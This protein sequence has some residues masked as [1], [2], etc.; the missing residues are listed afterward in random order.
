MGFEG[1]SECPKSRRAHEPALSHGV[2]RPGGSCF[3]APE[4]RNI[5]CMSDER[6]ASV[7]SAN[8]PFP[9]LIDLA[10]KGLG[11]A[12]DAEHELFHLKIRKTESGVVKLGHSIRYTIIC[13]LGLAGTQAAGRQSPIDVK[14][15]LGSLLRK[16]GSINDTGDL[17]LLFWLCSTA[18]PDEAAKVYSELDIRVRFTAYLASDEC[19][20][21]ELAWCLTAL[22]YAS[23]ALEAKSPQLLELAGAFYRKLIAGYGGKGIF[24]HG[25]SQGISGLFRAKIGCF[26]DQVYPIFALSKYFA[27]S[28][29]AEAL[30][31]AVECAD[32]ICTLQGNLGQWWWHYNSATGKV[33]GRYPVFSVHQDGMAPMALFELARTTGTDYGA[34]VYKGLAWIDGHNELNRSLIDTKRSLIWRNIH[35]PATGKYM[36]LV[37]SALFGASWRKVPGDLKIL[38]QCWPYHLGWLLYAF[39]HKA[40]S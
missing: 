34:P 39:A 17:G 38:Y 9:D 26:A 29:N 16:A 15:A 35:R 21:T 8:S 14:K 23:L 12:Y 18:F 13:L 27:A 11:N 1:W 10:L 36:E 32:A 33:V 22:S 40:F 20:T 6:Q 3:N 25:N 31:I 19:K 7:R 28:A 24:G 37:P 4:K 2:S 30:R 5:P